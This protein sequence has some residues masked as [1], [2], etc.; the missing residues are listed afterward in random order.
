MV[1]STKMN[2]YLYRVCFVSA[3]IN[4]GGGGGIPD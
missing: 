1:L 3:V 4:Y 2:D